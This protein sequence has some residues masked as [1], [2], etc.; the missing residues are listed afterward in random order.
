MDVDELAEYYTD[1]LVY[2]YRGKT[3]ARATI[4]LLV[5]SVLAEAVYDSVLN[6]FDLSAA[7][8]KQLDTLGKYIGVGRNIGV[9]AATDYFGFHDTV[10]GEPDNDNGFRDTTDS[11]V[12]STGRWYT[13]DAAST[14]ATEVDEYTYTLVIRL[15]ALTN[16]WDGTHYGAQIV[17]RDFLAAVAIGATGKVEDVLGANTKYYINGDIG[18]DVRVIIPYLPRKVGT[19]ID[20]AYTKPGE[21][22]Q[23]YTYP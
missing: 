2:Q 1:L 12:N 14:L 16:V 9:P 19:K 17:L 8:G 6:G 22:A 7:I 3:K 15:K 4:D 13:T 18:I 10:V 5:R 20:V 23:N 11:T 21:A